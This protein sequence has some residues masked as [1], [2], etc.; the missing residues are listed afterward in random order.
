MDILTRFELRKIMRR[1][2]FF[3]GITLIIVVALLGVWA[4]VS[5]AYITDKD[6]NDLKGLEAIPLRK[7]YNRQLAG[8]LTIEKIAA[9][10]KQHQKVIH[11]PKNLNEKGEL[12]NEAYVTYKEQS[13]QIDTLIRFAFSHSREYDHYII[14]SM[15]PSTA[16]TFYQER[17]DK[18]KEYIDRDY[19]PGNASAKENAF[20]MRMNKSIPVPFQMDYVTGWESVFEN[21]QFVLLISAF[22]IAIWLAPVFAGEYQSGAD[23]IILS[24]RYGRNKVIAAKLKAGLIVSLGLLAVGLGTYTLLMLGIFGFD[25]GSAS[26][27]MIKLFAPVPF[28]VFQTYLW[29]I[30]IGS[31]ACL[32]VGAVTLWLSSRMSTPFPVIIVIVILLIGPL[33]FP[34]SKSSRLYNHIMN[35]L[36]GKM[37]DGITRVTEYEGYSVFGQLIPSYKFATGFA[38]I[39]IALLLPF[40]YRAFKNHQVV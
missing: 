21:L 35:L 33:F 1:K 27:Q 4:L 28:T 9:A 17:L 6:G 25:G 24:S 11:D 29:A 32:T 15:T 23:A 2:S 18:V 22:V 39:V 14:D 16:K 13:Y 12:T 36:P 40:T 5:G 10:V 3:I 38:I 30:L 31:L 26:V 7:E 37:V 8:P 20:F 19:T 34:A